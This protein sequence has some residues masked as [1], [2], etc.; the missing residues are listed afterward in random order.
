MKKIIITVLIWVA[1]ASLVI[2]LIF[3]ILSNYDFGDT[4]IPVNFFT[5]IKEPLFGGI[6]GLILTIFVFDRWKRMENDI[7][8]VQ[9][10]QLDTLK[11]IRDD[12]ENI[13]KGRLES[14]TRKANAIESKIGGLLEEHPWISS[15]TENDLI[16]DSSSCRIVLNTCQYLINIDRIPLIYEYLYSWINKEKN[17]KETE[18][19]F[20]VGTIDDFLDLADFCETIL[21]DEFL[22]LQFA[23]E[24]VLRASNRFYGYPDYLIKLVRNG[25]YDDAKSIAKYIKRQLPFVINIGDKKFIYQPNKSMRAT[26]IFNCF[27]SL[28]L[29]Y[30]LANK[31]KYFDLYKKQLLTASKQINA[32][33]AA[34][35]LE[36]ESYAIMGDFNTAAATL[37]EVTP[38]FDS[39][40]R[41]E[42]YKYAR[43]Y[44]TIGDEDT[45]IEIMKPFLPDTAK[46]DKIIFDD[47]HSDKD[48]TNDTNDDFSRE[49]EN[50]EL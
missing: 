12:A 39:L 36:A 27:G 48:Q 43:I 42:K 21:G 40:S 10:E 26:Y 45:F 34:K 2:L 14:T 33:F 16:P 20:L 6:V 28:M 31:K 23:K 37:S 11:K 29:Y 1:I 38:D 8:S 44:R 35:C 32:E 9:K 18:K 41:N 49:T 22:G 13:I 17:N 25:N 50:P 46:D 24:G 47:S 15:V 5:I 30:S 4:E 3:N 7:D 19:S